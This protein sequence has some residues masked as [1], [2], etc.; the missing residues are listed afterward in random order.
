MKLTSRGK[1]AIQATLDMV[2]NSNG[3]AVKLQDIAQRQKISLFY[4]EQL[5]RKLRQAGVVKSVRGPGGGYVLAKSPQ[6]TK[7]GSVLAGVKEV[8][9]YRNKI[10]LA[11]DATVEAKAMANVATSLSASV[12]SVLDLSLAE[13]VQPVSDDSGKPQV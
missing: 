10:K 9:D 6:D 13:L 11:E 5:F 4:L 3:K 12:K 1:Y 8:M 7:V 2:K